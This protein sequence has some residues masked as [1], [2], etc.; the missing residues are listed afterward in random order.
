MRLII[1]T[2]YFPPEIG[3]PQNRLYEIAVR[4]NKMGVEI[5]VLTAM[6]NYP[7]M[8]V[9]AAYKGKRYVK[10]I[11]GGLTVHRAWIYAG[12]SRG[13]ISRLLN[14]F[15]FVFTSMFTGLFRLHK[16]DYI[17]CESPPLFLGISALFLKKAKRAKL[18]FN[19]ADLWPESAEKLGIITNHTLLGIA[20][21][22]EEHLYRKSFLI[23]G[24]SQGIVNN[25]KKRFPGKTVYWLANGVDLA[26]YDS[27][28]TESHWRKENHFTDADFLIL[29]AGIIGYAQGLDVILNAA[30]ATSDKTDMKWILLGVGPEKERLLKLK[31]GMGLKNVFFFDPVPKTSMPDVWKAVDA[32]VVPL[33]RLDIFKGII[34]SKIFEAMAM[35]KPLLLGLEGEAEELFIRGGKAGLSF[36]PDNGN[37]LA[38]KAIQLFNNQEEAATFGTSGREFVRANFNRD[39]IAQNFYNLLTGSS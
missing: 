27:G 26:F 23:T 35:C 29:Y 18:I 33:R 5:E 6:P 21:R 10:E 3:A 38:G 19:V 15:S 20:T 9:H 12:K 4:L 32:S 24:Q 39:T 25:I 30:K 17:F 2:Q 34:P 22:L 16:A 28:K 37:D 13:I 1:L 11:I 31:D 7:E 14:Y 36:I 8:Q